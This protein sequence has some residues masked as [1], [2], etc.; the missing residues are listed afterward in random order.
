MKLKLLAI[1]D[2]FV[3]ASMV[4]RDERNH[5]EWWPSMSAAAS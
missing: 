4:Y 5:R 3:A 2:R 1:I